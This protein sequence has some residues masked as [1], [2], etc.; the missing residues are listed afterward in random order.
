MP[1][2]KGN[3][4]NK[5]KNN[6]NTKSAH[7]S[8]IHS[9]VAQ[10]GDQGSILD[11]MKKEVWVSG[12]IIKKAILTQNYQ[13]RKTALLE[14]ISVYL[15]GKTKLG[16]N[17]WIASKEIHDLPENIIVKFKAK[18]TD[19]ALTEYNKPTTGIGFYHIHELSVRG[20]I[21]KEGEDFGD[22]DYFPMP[23]EEKRKG[24]DFLTR[25]TRHFRRKLQEILPAGDNAEFHMQNPLIMKYLAVTA[26]WYETD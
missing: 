9:K 10:N 20:L 16:G 8:K 18:I 3:K 13:Q 15:M 19:H 1:P 5:G 23:P 11:W 17:V 24:D 2:K 6:P 4:G 21:T 12:Q 22:K 25:T 7:D 26:R 14:N